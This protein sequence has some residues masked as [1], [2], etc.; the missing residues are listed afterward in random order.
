[1]ARPGRRRWFL[2]R[3]EAEGMPEDIERAL[4]CALGIAYLP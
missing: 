3:A 2:F 1:V 4:C